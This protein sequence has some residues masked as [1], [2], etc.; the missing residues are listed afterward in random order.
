M[1]SADEQLQKIQGHYLELIIN[2]RVEGNAVAIKTLVQEI[3]EKEVSRV[4][5]NIALMQISSFYPAKPAPTYHI[6]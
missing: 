5:E 1:H 6:K 2:I 3:I 4:G